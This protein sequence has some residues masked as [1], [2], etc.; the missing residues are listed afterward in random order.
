MKTI[1]LKKRT[2]TIIFF[3]VIFIILSDI[4]Y[5][6]SLLKYRFPDK[7]SF[8]IIKNKRLVGNCLLT[9]VRRDNQKEFNILSFH[10]FKGLGIQLEN[11]V[12]SYINKEFQFKSTI[13]TKGPNR[14]F[15]ISVLQ[16]VPNVLGGNLWM[17]KNLQ[18]SKIIE[19]LKS[20]ELIMDFLS[21][22]I[23]LSKKI[24]TLKHTKYKYCT[25]VMFNTIYFVNY[26]IDD[27]RRYNFKDD[28]IDVTTIRLKI[29]SIFNTV[30]LTHSK[31]EP[32]LFA[33]Y[34]I[35]KNYQGC[36]FPVEIIFIDSHIDTTYIFKTDKLIVNN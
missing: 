4:S 25:F 30:S 17:I 14:I 9:Y 29:I 20:K 11:S 34:K 31:I 3:I 7:I 28:L 21:S 8:K 26:E 32:F 19:T 13:I 1:F 15:E 16:Q 10:N 33:T 24:N 35:T 18:G 2:Y 36:T 27:G 23:I 22:F 12:Y 5:S 6:K